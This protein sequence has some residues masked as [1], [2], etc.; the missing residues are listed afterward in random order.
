MNPVEAHDYS[1][2]PGKSAGVWRD[3]VL[4]RW[5]VGSATV[6]AREIFRN[7][8]RERIFILSA[9]PFAGDFLCR[10]TNVLQPV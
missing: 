8:R 9:L 2:L 10:L 1:S 4:E 3:S 5:P 7:Q 6:A